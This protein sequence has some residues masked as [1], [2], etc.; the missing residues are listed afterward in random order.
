MYT[1]R[2]NYIDILCVMWISNDMIYSVYNG[3]E[4]YIYIYIYVHMYS[5]VFYNYDMFF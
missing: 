3:N 4:I 5:N 1:S 2:I